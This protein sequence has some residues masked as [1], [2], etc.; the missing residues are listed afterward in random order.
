MLQGS[1]G[2]SSLILVPWVHVLDISLPQRIRY[3][4]WVVIRLQ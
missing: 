1:M 3:S 2:Q 4:I